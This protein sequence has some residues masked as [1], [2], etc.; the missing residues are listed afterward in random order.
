MSLP[1][2]ESMKECTPQQSQALS[3]ALAT[4][5][6][7]SP[8]IFA[9]LV[10]SILANGSLSSCQTYEQL[11]DIAMSLI[12]DCSDAE[13]ASF[14]AGHP[15]IGES[16][17]LSA[18]SAQEQL[19]QGTS[20]AVLQSLKKLNQKYEEHYPGLIYV[21]FVNGRS[22]AEIADEMAALLQSDA[23]VYPPESQQWRKE[24][25]RATVDVGRIAKARLAK[26]GVD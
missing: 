1:S 25:E 8:L 19:S 22:R 9:K 20:P 3:D 10:P 14:I 26:F 23:V 5:F 18:L 2:L 16:S 7:P 12:S 6:E 13:K 21:T 11:I 4:I 17:G 24:L 15:R